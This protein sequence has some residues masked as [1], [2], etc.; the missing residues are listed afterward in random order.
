MEHQVVTEN[1]WLFYAIG[2]LGLFGRILWEARKLGTQLDALT[3]YMKANSLIIV[4][5]VFCY[6]AALS[7]WMWTDIL[8]AVGF[9]KGELNGGTVIAGFLADMLFNK[10]VQ[11][12][13]KKLEEPG[14]PPSP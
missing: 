10:A 6:N 4:Y 2:Y 1:M 3:A 5:S 11:S 8:S 9:F 7:L 13:K 14:E 12:T